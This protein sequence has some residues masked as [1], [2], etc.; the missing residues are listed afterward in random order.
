MRPIFLPVRHT[1]LLLI[2]ILAMAACGSNSRTS[3]VHGVF[4]TSIKADGTKLFVFTSPEGG[5]GVGHYSHPGLMERQAPGRQGI[6]H[7]ERLQDLII[8]ALELRLTQNGYCREGYIQLGS[9]IER[10]LFEIRGECN[11]AATDADRKQF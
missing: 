1:L 5:K 3:K 2:L 4:I 10:G 9:Y 8:E 11:E 7:R 6:A